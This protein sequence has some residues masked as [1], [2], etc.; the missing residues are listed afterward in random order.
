MI[1]RKV[2][3]CA[4][5]ALAI[6][7]VQASG[8]AA[9]APQPGA[10]EAVV[11]TGSRLRST[12]FTT[13]TPVT[14]MTADQLQAAAPST[15]AAGLQTLPTLSVG[16]GP[17]AGGGTANGG[18]NFL[19]LR[20]LGSDRTLTLLDGHRFITSNAAGGV[21]SNLIP[22]G[23]VSRVD[24]VT[25][26]A[27]AAYG[28]DAVGG[29][30]NF[31]L[32]THYTGL[33]VDGSVGRSMHNDNKEVKGT[34]T[35]GRELFGGRGHF[36]TSAEYFDNR[37]V[38]GDA[39][40]AK[41]N[42]GN[43]IPNPGGTP[44]Q[45]VA[46]DV[47]TP[48][49]TGGLI[50]NGAGGAVASNA[51]FQGIQFGPGGVLGPYNYGT[52]ASNR[53]ITSG[54]Q[55]GGDG[56]RV[57]TGQEI[58][59][60]LERATF[61]ARS[62]FDVTDHLNVFVEGTYGAT[63]SALD[64]SPTTG[65]LTIQRDNAFLART[66]PGLVAQMTAA[67]VP[68]L[69]LNRLTLE[70]GTTKTTNMNFTTLLLGGMQGDIAG[71]NWE[72]TA[73]YGTN[74]NKSHVANNLI[75]A[76]S[77]FAVDAVVNPA[78]GS[79]VCRAT[80]PGTTFNAAATGCV[81]FNPF[82]AGAPSEAALNYVFGE[83][84]SLTRTEQ[85]VAQANISRELFNLPAGPVQMAAGVEYRKEQART[86]V[87]PISEG[88]GYRLVNAQ[89][90]FGAYTIKEAFAEVEAPIL[91]D[92][93]LA[94]DVS[95]NM[96]G[97]HTEYST[98]GG[99]NTWKIGVNWNIDGQLRFRGTR[100]RDIRAPNLTELYATGRQ[101]N[102]TIDDIAFTGRTYLSVPNKTFGN[103]D[104]KPERANTLVLGFVYRPTWL[105]GFNLAIDHYSIRINGAIGNIGG[106]NAVQQCNLANQ[107]SEV[108]RFVIRDAS[109]AV[110]GTTTQPFNLSVTKTDGVDV[111]MG[112]RVP[113]SNF[114][115]LGDDPGDLN[116][117]L[118]TGYISQRVT[119][120]PLVPI[121][122]NA[123]GVQGS[124]KVRAN[125][126]ANYTKGKWSTQAQVRYIG[127]QIWDRNRTIGV[128][129]NFNHIA[130][131]AYLD[132]QISYKLS[133]TQEYY[134]NIQNVL[135]REPAFSPN[136]GGATPT[137]TDT[138]LYDQVGRNIR[139]GFRLRY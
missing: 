34:V 9:Q 110:I 46:S 39:R 94:Q 54:F 66:A 10:V 13:P 115:F 121:T 133:E 27:S 67:G 112:Y 25:G 57:S 98:S 72:M 83:L 81:P 135:D 12:T 29:V 109:R 134:V 113:L 123:V 116:L 114:S 4:G 69:S 127:D 70:R 106:N 20:G 130:D 63:E 102:I 42:A 41:R 47:R 131:R 92:K 1:H 79:I 117:R 14:T 108:C 17:T 107:A 126:T 78:T 33:K 103:V 97:R 3:L 62:D 101:N 105:Q 75:T 28:S 52:L 59:R 100:S 124:P 11:V 88:G 24:V 36:I 58:V 45:V 6:Q 21:D 55:S 111:E 19:A 56:F 49:T 93:F 120:S 40:E 125:F 132:G 65:T 85:H 136:P 18:Q 43:I 99:V 61:F 96:A 90:F 53:G 30:I 71:W 138:G 50:V 77:A 38:R 104:L 35:Y 87:D 48:F 31:I 64:N 8:A 74:R 119:I 32:D 60:P 89:A 15:L 80:L 51:L 91:K 95:L 7:L 82:G 16:G 122:R 128:D 37:G 139:L 137:Q 73:Q 84:T 23:L 2:L 22:S 44:T 118:V 76:R 68:R 5:T 26:G 86:S 129:T